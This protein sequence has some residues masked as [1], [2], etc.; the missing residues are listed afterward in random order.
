[1]LG[2]MTLKSDKNFSL[3]LPSFIE[4]FDI[5][6][7]DEEFSFKADKNLMTLILASLRLEN[8]NNCTENICNTGVVLQGIF[9]IHQGKVDV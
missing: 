4:K 5:L 2:E 3:I 9:F 6:F 1:M 7:E 8:I